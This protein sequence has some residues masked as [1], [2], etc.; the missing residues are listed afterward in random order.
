V[1]ASLNKKH[2]T[3]M[4]LLNDVN[5]LLECCTEFNARH[6]NDD[7]ENNTHAPINLSEV[8][9]FLRSRDG[10]A[11]ILAAVDRLHDMGIH[12][13]PTLIVNGGSAIVS[14]A[15][16]ADEVYQTLRKEI[17]RALAVAKPASAVFNRPMFE[18]TLQS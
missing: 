3:E 1:Y 7:N 6:R 17:Q 16:R 5:L 18:I 4:G 11:S 9:A 12:S 10:E 13:I 8:E 2:F 14:G 15:A